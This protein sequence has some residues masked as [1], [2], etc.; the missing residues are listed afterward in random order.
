M[1]FG[2]FQGYPCP[3]RQRTSLLQAK[4]RVQNQD[5]PSHKELSNKRGGRPH[6][7]SAT[8]HHLPAGSFPTQKSLFQLGLDIPRLLQD[9]GTDFVRALLS[10]EGQRWEHFSLGVSLEMERFVRREHF[11]ATVGS[12][13]VY[14]THTFLEAPTD[15]T[16][17]AG[18]GPRQ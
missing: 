18:M 8:A 4:H 6:T 15:E 1:A 5:L 13:D 16:L 10:L 2:D 3:Q 11:R 12:F 17:L 9:L 7:W 14:D